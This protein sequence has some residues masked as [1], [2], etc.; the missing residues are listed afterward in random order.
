M[1]RSIPVQEVQKHNI[2]EDLWIVVD[3]TVYNLTDFAPE[4][5]GGAAIILRYA[6]RDAT[7]A[8]DEVHAPSLIK[9]AL[10]A[11]HIV[12]AL[13]PSS[14]TEEWAKPPPEVSLAVE[15]DAKPP[16]ESLINTHDFVAAASKTLTPKTWAFYSS[17]ATDLIT[18]SRNNSVYG[19]IVLRPKILVNVRD[20]DVSTTMLGQKMAAPIFCAPAAMAK[21][22]HRDGEKAL[23]RGMR[24]QGLSHCISTN[25]SYPIAEIFAAVDPA[26]DDEKTQGQ[27]ALPIFFQLYVDKQREKSEKLLADVEKLG[28]KAIFVTVDAPVPGKREADERVKADESLS[29]PMSGSKAKN[30]SK[31]GS[32]GRI[33]GNYIDSSLS[34]AD[35][36]WLRRNT[37]L[38]II[39]KGVMTAMDAKRAMEAGCEGI[40]L[41]NHGGRNLD[42]SP[43]PILVLLELQKCCPEIFD[44]MEVYVDGGI[45]R[46]TDIFKA[47]CL[48]ARTV[49]IGRGF[50][51]ALNYGQKGVE[52]YAEILKDELET[53]MRLCGITDLSQ[54]H[55]GL[56]NTRA[57]DH[58]IPDLSD[59]HPYAKWRPKA[60]I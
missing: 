7:K 10:P 57:V 28:V 3:N 23:A 25:A 49:G 17:A 36:P 52:K 22:V 58:L 43:I 50:L 13:D 46:G 11:S 51:F 48:G 41:S 21:L 8:Y 40:V 37:K 27:A 33:M 15:P 20:V 42:T 59:E 12:G 55:P 44:R 16:L 47:L 4:H 54:V 18:K 38:P 53:T 26:Q 39:L 30:D 29:T 14:I 60:R 2:P 34:W 6:G 32:L 19:E 31:G 45:M 24:A 5:P 9:S 1:V 56:L 35:L